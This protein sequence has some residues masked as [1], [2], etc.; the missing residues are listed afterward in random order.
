LVKGKKRNILRHTAITYH[1]LKFRDPM[2]TAYVAGKSV[3]LFADI[4]SGAMPVR[5]K[6]YRLTSFA[7]CTSIFDASPECAIVK[8]LSGTANNRTQ[9]LKNV[10]SSNRSK[11]FLFDEILIFIPQYITVVI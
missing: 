6:M 4:T 2:R 5:R 7:A 1:T 9:L 10:S 8:A 3:Y 11:V